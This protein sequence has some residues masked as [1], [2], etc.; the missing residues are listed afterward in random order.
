MAERFAYAYCREVGP[1]SFWKEEPYPT[2]DQHRDVVSFFRESL[3]PAGYQ[4]LHVFT[5]KQNKADVR[6]CWRPALQELLRHTE[7]HDAIIVPKLR[8]MFSSIQDM[9]ETLWRIHKRRLLIFFLDYLPKAFPDSGPFLLTGFQ[10]YESFRRDVISDYGRKNWDET[11]RRHG[12]EHPLHTKD[13]IR[14]KEIRHQPWYDDWLAKHE[15][16]SKLQFIYEVREKYNWPYKRIANYFSGN[17]FEPPVK[18]WTPF[19]AMRLYMRYSNKKAKAKK[20]Q[21]KKER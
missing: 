16:D 15:H 13:K 18:V 8:L 1:E 9:K 2:G 5:D 10:A 14:R 21:E 6:G 7:R 19:A 3:K 20:E 17:N 4:E 11:V 12:G